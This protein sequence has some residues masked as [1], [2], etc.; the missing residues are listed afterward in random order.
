MATA[1]MQLQF[2]G[3]PVRGDLDCEAHFDGFFKGASA[4]Q[5][6]IGGVLRSG[7]DIVCHGSATFATP[8][9]PPG[10]AV[11]AVPW[12]YLSKSHEA[13]PLPPRD[14]GEDEKR[15][16]QAARAALKAADERRAFIEHL[17]AQIARPREGGGADNAARIGP[18]MGNRVGHVQGGVIFGFA[19]ATGMAALPPE[20]RLT[21]AYAWYISAGMGKKLRARATILQQ[22]RTIAVVRTE[23]RDDNKRL[24]ME[25]LTSHAF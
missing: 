3:L 23:V 24:V 16:M 22:G 19:A 15:V 12:E 18:H 25:M 20:A 21:G 17:W 14:M 11:H 1:T 4:Q 6:R 5:G 2:T 10:V 8:P 9:A 13:A 7:G